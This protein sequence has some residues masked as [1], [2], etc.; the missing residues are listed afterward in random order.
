MI[1]K[2][3]LSFAIVLIVLSFSLGAYLG[4]TLKEMGELKAK[5]AQS[6]GLIHSQNKAIQALSLDTQNY[7]C[8]LESLNAYS[9]AKYESVLEVHKD[10]S[11]EAKLKSLEQALEI[12]NQP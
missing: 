3:I 1:N 10:E 8:D 6:E 7:K 4:K 2:F 12:F 9:K 5:L 11:C